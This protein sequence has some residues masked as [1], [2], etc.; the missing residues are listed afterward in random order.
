M[1]T[2]RIPASGQEFRV[3][4]VVCLARNYF[5]HIRELGNA[6]PDA[7]VLFIK[8]ATSIIGNGGKV[9]IPS[10]SRDCHH[11]V[12]LA[13]LIGR[14]VKNVPPAEAMDCIAGY[15]VGIDLTLRDVQAAL[16]AKGLPWEAAKG[17]D[18]ACPLSDFVPA[19]QVADPH[20]LPI[21]FTIDG[22]VKQDATTAL[23]M[24]KLP[25]I[26]SYASSLFTLE[27]GDVI[28]TGTPAGVGPVASGQRLVGEI[29]GVGRIEV[30]VA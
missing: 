20:A 10:T 28:L 22:A 19:A 15:G 26:I 12:E 6:V 3:G 14:T 5:D 29:A 25:E 30:T 9:V 27:A 11:E 17:F 23:M 16:K 8:P 4:K 1:A 7:P 18:T 13:V 2:V 21:R 24:R